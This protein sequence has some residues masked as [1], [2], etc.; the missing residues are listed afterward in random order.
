MQQKE[1]AVADQTARL[2]DILAEHSAQTARNRTA[3]NSLNELQ[4]KVSDLRE[5]VHSEDTAQA[6]SSSSS[7]SSSSSNLAQLRDIINT[8]QALVHEKENA[9]I[10]SK[11]HTVE[12]LQEQKARREEHHQSVLAAEKDKR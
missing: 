4:K 12:L 7:S 9:L 11:H 3:A 1:K 6:T 10:S 2:E 8:E 5:S